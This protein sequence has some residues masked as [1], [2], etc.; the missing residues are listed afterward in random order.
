MNWPDRNRWMDY[1][2]VGFY[3]I[4]FLVIYLIEIEQLII[5]D[6]SNFNYPAW[7]PRAMVDLTHWWGEQYH[8]SLYY[9]PMWYKATIWVDIFFSGPVYLAGIYAFLKKKVWISFPAL[10]QASM[11]IAIVFISILEECCG[12][13]AGEEKM[14]VIGSM[15][16]WLAAPVM[17]VFRTIQ[18]LNWRLPKTIN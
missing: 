17:V 9:R 18:I 15:L 1:F 16:L 2:I 4:A 13:Y 6:P 5:A 12:Q 7:P 11:L 14:I 10:I 8:H 3:S